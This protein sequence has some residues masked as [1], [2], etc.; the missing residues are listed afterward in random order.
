L[1][2]TR[3]IE[4]SEISIYGCLFFYEVPPCT[5]PFGLA[6]LF[7][8][9]PDDFV[10]PFLWKATVGSAGGT[11]KRVSLRGEI[12]CQAILE[13]IEPFS[14]SIEMMTINSFMEIKSSAEIHTD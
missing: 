2:D 1:A 6:S 13:T 14:S 9:V 3:E 10:I 5:S 8:I 12:G 4:Q 11:K 7:K